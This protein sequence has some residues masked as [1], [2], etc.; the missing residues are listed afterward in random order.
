MKQ[1][2]SPLIVVSLSATKSRGTLVICISSIAQYMSSP[3]NGSRA[4]NMNLIL[5]LAPAESAACVI[6]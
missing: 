1:T 5:K 6:S 4:S 2:V 3:A